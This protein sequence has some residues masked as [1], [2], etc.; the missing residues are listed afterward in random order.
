MTWQETL[1][2][3]CAN[4]DEQQRAWAEI[5]R[6]QAVVAG[7]AE[8]SRQFAFEV[9]ELKAGRLT[10]FKTLLVQCQRLV[11]AAEAGGE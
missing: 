2:L 3:G 8:F 6:L 4:A 7:L 5:E 9:E 1:Q 10:S 11:K